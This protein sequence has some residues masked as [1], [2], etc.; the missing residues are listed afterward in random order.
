MLTQRSLV[1]VSV[2]ADGNCQFHALAVHTNLDH[3]DLR[4]FVIDFLS[5]HTHLFSDFLT[6]ETVEGFLH[7]MALPASWGNHITLMAASR[8]L[9][10]HIHVVSSAGIR[11]V[12][13]PAPDNAPIWLAYN[14]VHYDAVIPASP[15]PCLAA[16]AVVVQP[17]VDQVPCS[18]SQDSSF[19]SSKS[20]SSGVCSGANLSFS[21]CN[22]TSLKMN[23]AFL[24]FADVIGLQESR[25]TALGVSSLAAKLRTVGYNVLFGSPVCQRAAAKKRSRTFF[26]GIPGGVALA[27][28]PNVAAQ[29]APLG[30]CDRRR[31][32]WASGRWLHAMLP[33]GCGRRTIHVM[34]FY[35]HSGQYSNHRLFESN[36]ALLRDVFAEANLVRDLPC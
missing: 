36:E 16:P 27:F 3:V 33:Y 28:R 12:D 10:R 15:E 30:S 9:N 29:L 20:L 17:S 1:R 8:L 4:S 2:P 32:L 14:G 35:G 25:H 22:I 26:N 13:C 23:Y 7:R 34:V 5:L 21:S 31:R 6:N 24:D 19:A 11:I 18:F